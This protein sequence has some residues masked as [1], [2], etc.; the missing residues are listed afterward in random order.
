MFARPA[1]QNGAVLLLAAIGALVAACAQPA[2]PRPD[3]SPVPPDAS[4][5]AL[6]TAAPVPSPRRRSCRHR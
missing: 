4:P 2:T 3:P 1:R 5:T 6:E